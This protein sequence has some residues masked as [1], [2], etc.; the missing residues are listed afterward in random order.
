[1][2]FVLRPAGGPPLH[3]NFVVAALSDLFGIQGR[4]GCSC[5]GPYGHRLLGIDETRARAFASQAAA[6]WLGVKPGW[7]RV[8]FAFYM[9]DAVADYII[10]AVHR[11]AQYGH[12]LLAD[13][14]FDPRSGLWS[15]RRPASPRPGLPAQLRRAL[16]GGPAPEPGPEPE[17]DPDSLLAAHLHQACA[18]LTGA[19]DPDPDATQAWVSDEYDRLRWFQLPLSCVRP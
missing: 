11:L 9:T 10:A 5:A 16:D 6:G 2:S 12:R 19:S 13:Y 15:H 3:H 18:V 8:S 7:T 14:R 1:M 4:G 17:R